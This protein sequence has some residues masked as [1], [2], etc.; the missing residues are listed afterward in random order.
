MR[1]RHFEKRIAG[2]R[3]ELTVRQ[4]VGLWWQFHTAAC[5]IGLILGGVGRIAAQEKKT[6][7]PDAD[8]VDKTRNSVVFL[9]ADERTS[10]KSSAGSG[11]GFFVAPGGE[12]VTNFHVIRGMCEVLNQGGSHTKV[13]VSREGGQDLANQN[14]WRGTKS[15]ISRFW[16]F[17]AATAPAFLW[18][19]PTG[20]VWGKMSSRS[21]IPGR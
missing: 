1:G 8:L 18:A 7:L 17:R 13:S 5:L 15:G 19:T 3:E 20:S 21:A 9:L 12:L 4:K 16:G 14:W 10:G 11:S 6:P 2:S